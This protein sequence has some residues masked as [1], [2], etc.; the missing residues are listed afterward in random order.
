MPDA[1]ARPMS[2]KGGVSAKAP[3]SDWIPESTEAAET[4][5]Q[6]KRAEVGSA[7]S[8]ISME[9]HTENY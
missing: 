1:I 7:L 5:V 8:S 3:D 9:L 4:V 6:Q 2:P